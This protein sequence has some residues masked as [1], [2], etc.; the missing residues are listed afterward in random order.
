MSPVSEFEQ[1]SGFQPLL[2]HSPN[3]LSN[4]DVVFMCSGRI[5]YDIRNILKD[6]K[7]LQGKAAVISVEELLPFPEKALKEQLSKLKKDAK[8][9]FNSKYL[10]GRLSGCRKKL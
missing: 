9:F 2:V 10:D 8:V 4:A 5:T 3:G 6:N 7:D 1:N